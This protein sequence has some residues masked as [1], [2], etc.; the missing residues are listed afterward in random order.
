MYWINNTKDKR[1]NATIKKCLNEGLLRLEITY[2]FIPNEN[3]ILYLINM[4]KNILQQAKKKQ[5]YFYCSI[6]QQ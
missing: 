3:E 6:M 5:I 1:L 4:L 2:T